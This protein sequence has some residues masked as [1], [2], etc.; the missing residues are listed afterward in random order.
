MPP[1][2]TVTLT[3]RRHH[4]VTTSHQPTSCLVSISFLCSR[5]LQSSLQVGTSDGGGGFP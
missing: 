5:R 3:W 2:G 1:A 4:L